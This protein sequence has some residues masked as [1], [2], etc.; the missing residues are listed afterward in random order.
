MYKGIGR[1]KPNK[2]A[3]PFLG[4]ED[5]LEQVVEERI[6]T[7]CQ[8]KELENVIEEIKKAHPYEEPVIDVYPLVGFENK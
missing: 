6:E 5:Y 2:E 8:N 3:K 4:K 7:V 1:F